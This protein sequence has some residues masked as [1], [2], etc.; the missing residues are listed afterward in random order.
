MFEPTS[1]SELT[2]GDSWP[3]PRYRALGVKAQVTTPGS[4]AFLSC[5]CDNGA[6]SGGVT[7]NRDEESQSD[8]SSLGDLP[9]R[10]AP[11]AIVEQLHAQHDWVQA[12]PCQPSVGVVGLS[13]GEGPMAIQ[14]VT[15]CLPREGGITAASGDT[16]E[17]HQLRPSGRRR[18]RPA[19]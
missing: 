5:G 12:G 14:A 16:H 18:R 3:H 2:S 9:S 19:G 8:R 7:E 13:V 11:A 6:R 1:R 4:G 15:G 17:A 10:P